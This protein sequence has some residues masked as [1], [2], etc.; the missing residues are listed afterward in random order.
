LRDICAEELR[1]NEAAVRAVSLRNLSR[2]S[3]KKAIQ[4]YSLVFHQARHH[5]DYEVPLD[6]FVP[7]LIHVAYYSVAYS[8]SHHIEAAFYS[9]QAEDVLKGDEN[10][11]CEASNHVALPFEKFCSERNI[12]STGTVW[13]SITGNNDLGKFC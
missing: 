11:L 10:D 3:S 8:A 12:D 1:W 5:S 13:D 9:R 4:F 6:R 2:A 7:T